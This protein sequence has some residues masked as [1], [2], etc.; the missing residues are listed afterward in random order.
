MRFDELKFNPDGSI[1]RGGPNA[2]VQKMLKNYKPTSAASAAPT[3][4]EWGLRLL[5]QT[6]IPCMQ[7]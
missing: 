5:C 2:E 1:D 3:A 6:T 7:S 4:L